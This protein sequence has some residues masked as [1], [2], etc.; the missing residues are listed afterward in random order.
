LM[1]G[2]YLS[3]LQDVGL[4]ADRSSEISLDRIYA[5]YGAELQFE[6]LLGLAARLNLGIGQKILV[7][8]A[9][10]NEF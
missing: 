8:F 9:I 2:L 5:S 3:L 1:K 10:G 6:T 4:V 7:F